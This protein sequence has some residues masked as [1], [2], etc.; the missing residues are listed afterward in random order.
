MVSGASVMNRRRPAYLADKIALE[1]RRRENR[2]THAQPCDCWA[3]M[4]RERQAELLAA[5]LARNPSARE[6]VPF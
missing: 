3:C 1:Q 4:T 2:R 5:A 6:E